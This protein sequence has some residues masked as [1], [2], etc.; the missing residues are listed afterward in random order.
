MTVE[1]DKK[2]VGELTKLGIKK[3]KVSSLYLALQIHNEKNRSSFATKAELKD[4]YLTKSEFKD[5][6]INQQRWLIGG[7][8]SVILILIGILF[9]AVA[10]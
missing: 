6:R 5:Y 7:F 8:T 1:I 10:Q 3:E 9:K 4:N 2:I